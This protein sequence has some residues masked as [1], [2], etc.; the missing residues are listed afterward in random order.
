MRS[1]LRGMRK[2][3]RATSKKG[4]VRRKKRAPQKKRKSKREQ[5]AAAQ[6]KIGERYRALRGDL[7][8]RAR[9]L[10]VGSEAIAFGYGGVAAVARAT[11][12]AL[13]SVGKGVKEV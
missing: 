6:A 1:F 4:R 3:N 11:G 5:R 10:F 12:M 8:E 2:K 13:S 9:R 7:T